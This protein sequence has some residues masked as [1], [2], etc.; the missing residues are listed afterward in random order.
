MNVLWRLSITPLPGK[1][2]VDLTGKRLKELGHPYSKMV[3]SNMTRARES[4]DIIHK[5]L[6]HLPLSIDEML[7]EGA[8]IPPEPPIGNWRSESEVCVYFVGYMQSSY[9]P[10]EITILQDQMQKFLF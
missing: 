9:F 1:E 3:H 5:H 2:Q 4:A 6:P 8:P 10:F 7:Q